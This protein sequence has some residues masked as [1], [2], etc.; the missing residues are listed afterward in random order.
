MLKRIAPGVL[1]LVLSVAVYG[2]RISN[3]TVEPDEVPVTTATDGLASAR[4]HDAD[5]RRLPLFVHLSGTKWLTPFPVY[6]S[7]LTVKISRAFGVQADAVTA[8]RRTAAMMGGLDV[9]LV[10][11]VVVSA[12]Q[13]SVLAFAAG[14]MVLFSPA[15]A[16]FS[17]H[18]S[19]DGVWQLPFIATWVAGLVGSVGLSAAHSRWMLALAAFALAA[20]I[21]SQPSAGVMIPWF[22]AA[23]ILA[24]Y[25]TRGWKWRDMA[26]I[27]GAG[28]CALLPAALWFARYP[29]TYID[30]LGAWMLHPAYI[31]NPIDWLRAWKNIQT[32]SVTANVFW[33][34]FTPSH[35]FLGSGA[36]TNA[37]VLLAIPGL[38]LVYGVI[39]VVRTRGTERP[40]R[41]RML[42]ELA[43][44]GFL[45]G[46]LGA[47]TFKQ[48]W[49]IQ[50]TLVLVIFAALLATIALSALWVSVSATRRIQ[51]KISAT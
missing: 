11:V 48:R 13:N 27:V 39:D 16:V 17:T 20:S 32:L 21:Y 35:L 28:A 18:A 12:F 45:I 34:F 49:A 47:A 37:P 22:G 4:W 7:A 25:R 2:S 42:R 9:L 1:L 29:L 26:V 46:P 40:P 31:R 15:H 10:Y 30:T 41:V 50:R 38:L 5:G 6:A 19:E 33:D 44:C 36:G 51:R 23:T 24:V 14:L 3:G 8:A 43:L